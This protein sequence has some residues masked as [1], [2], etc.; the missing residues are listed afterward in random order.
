M[1]SEDE[2]QLSPTNDYVDKGLDQSR[3]IHS[4]VT[5]SGRGFRE[6]I[7]AQIKGQ[8][9]GEWLQEQRLETARSNL[10]KLLGPTTASLRQSPP[11]VREGLDPHAPTS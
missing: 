9:G 8:G 3:G 5:K 6:K 4:S 10:T 7:L 11:P 2:Q 1:V